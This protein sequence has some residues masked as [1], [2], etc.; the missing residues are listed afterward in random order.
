MQILLT[1]PRRSPDSLKNFLKRHKVK[2]SHLPQIKI[3]LLTPHLPKIKP[4]WIILLSQNSFRSVRPRLKRI[5]Q[6]KIA[7]VGP[8][9]KKLVQKS[10]FKVVFTP[11]KSTAWE[12]AKSLPAK[13][14]ETAWL[15]SGG[16]TD[17]RFF[18]S[19]K[20][21][22]IKIREISTYAIQPISYSENQFKRNFTGLIDAVVF[23]SSAGVMAFT[24]N[25]KIE[26]TQ[27]IAVCLEPTTAHTAHK[28]GF[29]QVIIA[30]RATF[31]SLATVLK[32]LI[33]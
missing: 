14:G 27:P 13:R 16:Q 9:T 23:T 20:K 30:K 31:R 17:K 25:F 33:S 21:R 5:T 18:E 8:M 22:N 4:D 12:L 26:S 24:K 28:S 11:K 32:K 6:A 10:G 19:L 1:H 2:F 3:K 15:F 7:T 29:R